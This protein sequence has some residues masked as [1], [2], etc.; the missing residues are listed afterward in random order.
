[1]SRPDG[2]AAVFVADEGSASVTV[3]N[4]TERTDY[5]WVAEVDGWQSTGAFTTGALPGRAAVRLEDVE[6]EPTWDHL[7]LPVSCG[8]PA[9]VGL[10]SA[11]G[12]LVWYQEITADS[13]LG[14]L[15]FTEGFRFTEEHTMLVVVGRQAIREFDL[16]GEV[17]FEAFLGGAY[18][19]PI[20]HDVHRAGEWTYVLNA[21]VQEEEGVAYIMDGLYV[22]DRSG[23]IV[24]NWSLGDHV[25]PSGPGLQ[26]GFWASF[27]GSS[28]DFSHANG[29][30]LSGDELVLSFRALS[31]V[32]GIAGDPLDPDFGAIRWVLDGDG[33]QRLGS[34]LA[35]SSSVTSKVGFQD[36]HSPSTV[37]AGSLVLFDNRAAGEG[38]SRAIRLS[39]DPGAGTAEITDAWDLDSHCAV[40]GSA[41]ELPNGHVVATCAVNGTVVE[42]APGKTEP[43][44]SGRV[45]CQQDGILPGLL[46]RAQPVDLSGVGLRR[47]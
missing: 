46:V 29:V 27:F 31:T 13:E 2:E 14:S 35:L 11:S 42:F 8:V 10:M 7:A 24:A 1:V 38:P 17:V 39:M 28:V 30:W 47:R 4:L 6:G 9:H 45:V 25:V 18:D 20:H 32:I 5:A 12:D 44:W 41:Y 36:Q 43:V 40:Q 33:D 16:T 22:H 19:T 37:E 15:L 23:D 34:D 26:G 3:W 21:S